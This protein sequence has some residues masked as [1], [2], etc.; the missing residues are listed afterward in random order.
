MKFLSVFLFFLASTGELRVRAESQ[1]SSQSSLF[2]PDT[3]VQPK[4]LISGCV[5][6]RSNEKEIVQTLHAQAESLQAQFFIEYTD[7]KIHFV[8]HSGVLKLTLRDG[9]QLTLPAG[10]SVWVAEV[11]ENKK[12]QI[13]IIEPI[14]LKTHISKLGSI[15][16]GSFQALKS[17]MNSLVK[18][19]GR[20]EE[21]AAQYYESLVSRRIASAEE[22]E[23]WKQTQKYKKLQERDRNRKILFDRTFNR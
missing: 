4:K 23:R 11:Q 17:E 19:W 7:K 20:T 1:T 15:W 21:L 18:R 9:R 22:A 10:F 5:W 2:C 12:N 14:D 6:V 8:N 13:G 16:T 3:V